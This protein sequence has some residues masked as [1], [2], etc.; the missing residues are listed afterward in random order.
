MA[1]VSTNFNFITL[2]E[3]GE[4]FS[5]VLRSLQTL[6]PVAYAWGCTSMLV[7]LVPDYELEHQPGLEEAGRTFI[8]PPLV[9]V[10]PHSSKRLQGSRFGI[11]GG[12]EL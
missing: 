3:G 7:P 8:Y 2:S 5:V 6:Y 1:L 12:A 10:P 4:L 9:G 11:G